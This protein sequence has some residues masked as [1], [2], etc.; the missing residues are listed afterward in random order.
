MT[1]PTHHP[2]DTLLIDYAGGALDEAVSLAVATH[3]ALCPCCRLNVAEMEAVGGA[4]LEEIEP[5]AVD[6]TSLEAVLARLD[7]HPPLPRAAAPVRPSK[8]VPVPLIPEPLRRYIGDDPS[9]LPW[10]RLMRGMDC[11]DIPLS[12]TLSGPPGSRSKA[13]LMRLGPGV[14]PPHHTHRGIELTL[15]LDGGFTDDLGQFG[16][17]DLSVADGSIRHRP[18]ADEE[19][20]LCLAVTDGLLR[21]T[22]ALGLILNPFVKF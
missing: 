9:R 16:R 11:C 4:L 18:V 13:R 17:G 8:P 3:L 1:V 12:R 7:E 14:G 5:E 10:T 22:G 6:P 20:C 19:G 15:V 2:G 21:F